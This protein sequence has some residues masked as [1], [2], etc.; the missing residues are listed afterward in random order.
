MRQ[1]INPVFVGVL[2]SIALSACG[3]NTNVVS[4]EPPTIDSL[5]YDNKN[6]APVDKG[7]ALRAAAD[8]VNRH[9][10]LDVACND[11]VLYL[12]ASTA[13]MHKGLKQPDGKVTWTSMDKNAFSRMVKKEYGA[14]N[15]MAKSGGRKLRGS[16]TYT[17]PKYTVN[18]DGSVKIELSNSVG[19]SSTD[20][21]WLVRD[22]A[23]PLGW[24]IAYE[25][26]VTTPKVR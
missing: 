26:S 25:R 11:S 20:L 16:S 21:Q 10:A 23:Q 22:Y 8:L 1:W 14:S 2:L 5:V 19:M 15:A 18:K 12:Y 17:T 24:Q 6:Q 7:A 4:G 3:A 13:Q 9:E